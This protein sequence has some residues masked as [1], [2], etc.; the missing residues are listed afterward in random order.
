MQIAAFSDS[1]GDL[2]KIHESD[3][4]VIAGDIS[5]LQLQRS[6]FLMM[7]WF[8]DTFLPWCKE[9]PVKKIYL[10]P[11]NHDFWFENYSYVNSFITSAEL[12]GKLKILVDEFDEFEG[13]SFYGTPWCEGPKGWAF[14]PVDTEPLYDK[15]PDCSVLISHQPPDIDKLGC[16]YPNTSSERNFGSKNLAK[17]IYE[18]KIDYV[19]CG[20]IHTG[21]HE[22]KYARTNFY[23][24]SLLNE[25]YKPRQGVTYVQCI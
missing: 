13:K 3:V 16:S 1:H 17:S 9:Q 23:N 22:V 8:V 12:D 4:L 11:G 7:N 5:P 6:P 19:F 21:T 10:V 20:H 2:P 24:V 25:A 14:V 15:I 18:H